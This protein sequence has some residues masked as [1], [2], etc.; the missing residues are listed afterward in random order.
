MSLRSYCLARLSTTQSLPELMTRSYLCIPFSKLF[1]DNNIYTS[2]YLFCT[3]FDNSVLTFSSV[4]I[5]RES[6]KKFWIKNCKKLF[7]S[8]TI[9][10]AMLSTARIQTTFGICSAH[11]AILLSNRLSTFLSQVLALSRLVGFF[12]KMWNH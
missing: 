6:L 2:L 9:V 7:L 10:A 8:S 4:I 3:R 11:N 12:L 5:L 1:C